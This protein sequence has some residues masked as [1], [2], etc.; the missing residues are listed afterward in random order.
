MQVKKI[1]AREIRENGIVVHTGSKTYEVVGIVE[2]PNGK[3]V[4]CKFIVEGVD[5][6]ISAEN[7]VQHIHCGY[8]HEK[9]SSTWRNLKCQNTP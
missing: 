4:E 2:E 8:F 5:G 6:Y 3:F 7:M 1:T 9:Y